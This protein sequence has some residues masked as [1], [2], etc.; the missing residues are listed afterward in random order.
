MKKSVVVLI[1]AFWVLLGMAVIILKN[2]GLIAGEPWLAIWI[3]PFW[4]V[5]NYSI[6]RK[7]NK[8]NRALWLLGIISSGL[9]ITMSLFVIIANFPFKF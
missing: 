8:L 3:L 6:C 2:R 1:V 7:I 5:L 4:L 9:M